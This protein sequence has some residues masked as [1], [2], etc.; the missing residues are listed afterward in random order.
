MKIEDT[1]TFAEAEESTKVSL[2]EA[3]SDADILFD[4]PQPS[5]LLVLSYHPQENVLRYTGII[6]TDKAKR[7]VHEAIREYWDTFPLDFTVDF[8]SPHWFLAFL[9]EGGDAPLS[10]FM[11]SKGYTLQTGHIWQLGDLEE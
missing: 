7:C 10:S 3:Y 4:I 5:S 11:F 8:S 1:R 6:L 2:L 9:R